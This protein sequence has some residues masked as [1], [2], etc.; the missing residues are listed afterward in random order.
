MLGLQGEEVIQELCAYASGGLKVKT[1]PSQG[2]P[3]KLS[4]A[5]QSSVTQLVTSA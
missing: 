5:K 4:Q 1:E 2:S 3:E